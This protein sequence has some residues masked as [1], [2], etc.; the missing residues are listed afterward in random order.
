MW[1]LTWIRRAKEMITRPSRDQCYLHRQEG[2]YID[3]EEQSLRPR[4]AFNKLFVTIKVR[5][6]ARL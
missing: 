1:L 5:I 2:G 4:I 6:E 3:W